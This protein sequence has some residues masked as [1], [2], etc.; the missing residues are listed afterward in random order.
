[1][2]AVGDLITVE[3]FTDFELEW[4]WRITP[5][6][7]NG[8]KYFVTESRPAS[9][10]HEYQMADDATLSGAGRRPPRS[11]TCCQPKPRPA[12]IPLALR[13]QSRI[14]VRGQ[15]VQHWLNGEKVLVYELGSPQVHVA[16]ANSK[17]KEAHRSAIRSKA[18]FY[19][20]T[21]TAKL[22]FAT[23]IG[24]TRRL[25]PLRQAGGHLTP[26]QSQRPHQY[27]PQRR[28][29]K[30]AHAGQR[31]QRGGIAVGLTRGGIVASLP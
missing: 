21:T 7:N 5:K 2:A 1:M 4:E 9:P 6:G 18:R 31:Q 25:R 13:K 22:G 27:P 17:F 26:E 30:H 19:S 24:G 12:S 15:Q 28:P 8:I 10:G 11:T 14:A 23:S 16:I 3:Q 29:Q 20:P